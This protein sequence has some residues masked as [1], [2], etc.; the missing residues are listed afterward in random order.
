MGDLRVLDEHI[1]PA[2]LA[3]LN[4]GVVMI[5]LNISRGGLSQ[6][7]RN[8]HD[9]S[10]IANDFKIRYAF[11]DTEFSGAYMT[12]VIKGFEEPIS[13][14]LVDH[15]AAHPGV[16]HEHMKVLRDELLDLGHPRPVILAFGVA[17][18][19]L[20][21]ENLRAD[22]Y[23]LLVPLTH[24]SHRISKEKYRDDAH[25]QILREQGRTA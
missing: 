13:G 8:F 20:L 21:K 19:G 25:R 6:P 1:N 17:A 4:P 11:H 18:H 2:L 22:E 14:K 5:G 9:P 10:A 24:Y 12:D 3:T 16:I 15:L 7:F 23:S